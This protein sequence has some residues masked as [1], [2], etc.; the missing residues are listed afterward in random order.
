MWQLKHYGTHPEPSCYQIDSIGI[1]TPARKCVAADRKA[2]KNSRYHL[3][4]NSALL[5]TRAII[6]SS[7][8][9]LPFD[10]QLLESECYLLRGTYFP[11]PGATGRD[12]LLA[13]KMPPIT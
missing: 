8:Q 10:F 3:L 12:F 13:F 4:A 1:D 6:G 11:T 5:P 9:T 2:E 7:P